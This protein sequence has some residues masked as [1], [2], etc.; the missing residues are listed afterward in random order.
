MWYNFGNRK[1]FTFNPTS[2]WPLP[3]CRTG[4]RKICSL[5]SLFSLSTSLRT[6]PAAIFSTLFFYYFFFLLALNTQHLNN[7]ARFLLH[8]FTLSISLSLY[9]SIWL[10]DNIFFCSHAHALFFRW[11]SCRERCER[12]AARTVSEILGSLSSTA[13]YVEL[14]PSAAQRLRNTQT[15]CLFR[16]L[17]LL[18]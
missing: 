5:Q 4:K 12:T 16:L 9:L 7:S 14:Q 8:T 11:V 15:I 6:P 18:G 13:A 17:A 1:L 10:S 2:E 3:V